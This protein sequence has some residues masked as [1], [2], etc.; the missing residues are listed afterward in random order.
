MESLDQSYLKP[1]GPSTE[2]VS[3]TLPPGG[4]T[5]LSAVSVTVRLPAVWFRKTI[6]Q[7]KNLN[8]HGVKLGDLLINS[9]TT[10]SCNHRKHKK[11]EKVRTMSSKD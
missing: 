1:S 8:G 11:T 2:H 9:D 4:M 10:N 6:T 7:G 5:V 3:V